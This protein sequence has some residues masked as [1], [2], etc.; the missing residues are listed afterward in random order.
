ML[1]PRSDGGLPQ[2]CGEPG[3]LL[4]RESLQGRQVVP[5]VVEWFE[6]AE[7]EEDGRPE[8]ARL[9]VQRRGDQVARTAPQKQV[10]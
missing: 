4:G 9:A 1:N 6:P 2:L 5:L 8:L 7:V 3:D 10:L